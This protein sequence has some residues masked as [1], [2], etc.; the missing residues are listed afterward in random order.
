MFISEV[1]WSGT[2]ASSA[3]EWLELYNPN[4]FPV[5]LAG[6]RL[7]ADDGSPNIALSGVIA[8]HGF[9]LLERTDDTTVVDIPADLIYTGALGNGGETLRLLA[10]NGQTIDTANASGG[11]WPAGSTS[12][13][14]SMERHAW[15]PETDAA[16]HTATTFHGHDAQGNPIRGTPRQASGP[17]ATPTPSP[18][19]PPTPRP[20]PTPPAAPLPASRYVRLGEFLPHP[21][22][23]W[24]R[25]GSIDA[26]DEFI[27]IVNLGPVGVDL[28]GWYLDDG[29]GGSR[30]YRLG[31]VGLNPG[32]RKTFFASET[33]LRLNDRGDTVRLLDPWGREVDVVTYR[34]ASAWNLSWCRLA[35]L[36]HAWHYPCWPTPRARNVPYGTPPSAPTPAVFGGAPSAAAPQPPPSRTSGG[37]PQRL[38]PLPY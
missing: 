10:P 16:W 9:F 33:G 24:N 13:R 6:W 27:E 23:D 3:D 21:R 12:P 7:V 35:T 11:P 1:A 29:P 5:D 20:T 4:P 30:P 36:E 19:L 32:G 26:G 14:A 34:D 25:D 8:P 22:Y 18:T 28:S 38:R 2:Q 17:A 15:G 37:F 31:E